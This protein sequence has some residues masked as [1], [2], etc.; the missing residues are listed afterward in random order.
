MDDKKKGSKIKE[1]KV[2]DTNTA[3]KKFEDLDT[4]DMKRYQGSGNED[5]NPENI[6]TIKNLLSL[7]GYK[8]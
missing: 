8:C 6:T 4:E 5:V 2:K 3:G 7:N 1:K